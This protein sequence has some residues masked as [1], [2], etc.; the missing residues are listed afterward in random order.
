[1]HPTKEREKN[2]PLRVTKNDLTK[3]FGM[4]MGNIEFLLS[5]VSHG[6]KGDSRTDRGTDRD[7]D[8]HRTKPDDLFN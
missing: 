1:M 7:T 3:G 8:A 6:N 5:V 4:I 2:I